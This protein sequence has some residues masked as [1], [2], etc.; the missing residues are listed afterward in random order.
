MRLGHREAPP[1]FCQRLQG[2]SDLGFVSHPNPCFGPGQRAAQGDR[3]TTFDPY[4]F[5][6]HM[7]AYSGGLRLGNQFRNHHRCLETD[8]DWDCAGAVAGVWERLVCGE[9]LE[10]RADEVPP[11]V[12]SLLPW[13]NNLSVVK[14]FSFSQVCNS[15]LSW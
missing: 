15:A 1:L 8:L 6:K 12:P 3:Q 14:I 11:R 5:G 9:S 10:V 13:A 4:S 2:N 7:S